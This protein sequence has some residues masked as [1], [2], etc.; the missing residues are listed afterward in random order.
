MSVAMGSKRR[1]AQGRTPA[2]AERK[3][4][5]CPPWLP[6]WARVPASIILL[7]GVSA[8]AFYAWE[9][10]GYAAAAGGIWALALLYTLWQRSGTFSR[11]ATV[12]IGTAMLVAALAGAMA[13][14]SV[15]YGG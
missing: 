3:G 4:Q 10:L 13:M 2:T 14:Y 15:G 8:A 5:I 1:L 9:F 11:Y 7:L 6:G 12:W